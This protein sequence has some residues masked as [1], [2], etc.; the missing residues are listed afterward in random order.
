MDYYRVE[1]FANEE[2]RDAA[3]GPTEHHDVRYFPVDRNALLGNG[4]KLTDIGCGYS[5]DHPAFEET[6]TPIFDC[7]VREVVSEASRVLEKSGVISGTIATWPIT[8]ARARYKL[9]MVKAGEWLNFDVEAMSVFEKVDN[10]TMDRT[11]AYLQE[12]LV[13]QASPMLRKPGYRC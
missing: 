5:L 10:N 3:C 12:R 8:I 6:L 13:D 2:D 9:S 7:A 11:I 4:T 1:A